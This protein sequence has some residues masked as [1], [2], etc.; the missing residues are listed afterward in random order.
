MPI[1]TSGFG[2]AGSA[3]SDIFGAVGELKMAKGYSAAAGLAGQNA[4]IAAQSARIQTTM[5]QRQI[6]QTLGGQRADIAGAG[7]AASGSAL[8]LMRDSAQQ[9]GLTKQ[10]IAAQGAI[11]VNGYQAEQASYEAQA[12][13]AKASASGGFI[14]GLFDVAATVVAF[15]DDRMKAGIVE[16]S[17]R[18][19]GLG[20]YEFNYKGSAQRFRGVLASEVERI[21]P[22]AITWIDGM[23]AVNYDMIQMQPEVVNA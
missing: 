13:A 8:D 3:V 17:R 9:G 19:D 7:L 6:T 10:L 22:R 16:V 15:S 5:A 14:K 21:Y 23:R 11:N 18:R 20:V 4:E 12:S 2:S 1:S